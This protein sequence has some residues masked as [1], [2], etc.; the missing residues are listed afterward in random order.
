MS[1]LISRRAFGLGDVLVLVT[2]VL[3]G[4]SFTVIKS[5]YDEFTPL[6]FAA[7]RFVIASLGM[8]LILMLLRQ[9]LAI[10]R[11]DLFR[12]ATV[13]IFHVGF[14]QIF[15]GV[16]LR[17]T[18][19]SNSILIINTGPVITVL[20]VWLTRSEPLIWRHV[21]GILLAAAGVVLLIEA[22]GHFSTGYLKGDLLTLLG[23]W[24]YGVTPVLVLPL[25][26]RYSTLSVMTSSMLFGTL[27]LLAVGTPEL[28]R[29]SWAV[30]PAAW[31]QLGYAA[32]GAGTL[33]YLF[34]YEGIRRIGPTRVAAYTYLIPPVGVLLAV[35]VLREPFGLLHLAGAAV[36]LA[37]VAL[38][39]WPAA[40]RGSV[41][42]GGTA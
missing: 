34:W 28:A 16:G 20:M 17:Y 40:R 33:G 26:Q 38:A 9:P 35:Q 22:S 10:A 6:A 36:T 41:S 5:A 8:L 3:W 15:F 42:T 37:G 30:S 1:T 31:T 29:Q 39:R 14:Y 7:V 27:L 2:V 21:A 18:T 25:Y 24:S 13:G 19:A 4:A 23:A 11:R 12:V 32:L